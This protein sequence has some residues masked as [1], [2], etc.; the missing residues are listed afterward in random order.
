VSAYDIAIVGLGAMGSAAAWQLARRGSRVIG[1]DRFTPPH[2]FGSTHGHTRIIREA[3]FE[4]PLYVPLVQRAYELWS[5]LSACAGEPLFRQTGGLTIGRPDSTLVRGSRASATEHDLRWEEWGADEIRRRVPALAPS[6]EMV[7]IWEPRAGVLLPERSVA[8]MLADARRHGAELRFDTPVAGWTPQ[9][10]RIVVDTANG[11]ISASAV[12]LAAG[13]WLPEV[14]GTVRLPLVLERVV[15]GW[16]Q[17]RDGNLGTP[18]AFPVFILE[19]PDGR[20]VYGLP[21]VGQG[22]KLAGHHGGERTTLDAIRRT[23]D[24]SDRARLETIAARWV[25][26]VV[27]ASTV[28]RIGLPLYEHPR[29]AL[30]RGPASRRL[31]R[32]RRQRLFG[33]RVQVRAGNRRNRRDDGGGSGARVRPDAVR[34]GQIRLRNRGIAV[35]GSRGP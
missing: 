19:E 26:G 5:D 20:I 3:Y 25:P 13:P 16:F 11:S 35:A 23:V 9:H 1:F 33:T 7:A 8:A 10:D 31:A 24:A 29:P 21:D 4:H 12:V 34:A 28:R 17:P 30:H 14:M 18:G 2:A 32:H 6:G 27:A 22:V 15:Q